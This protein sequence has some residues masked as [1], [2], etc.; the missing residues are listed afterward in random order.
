MYMHIHCIFDQFMLKQVSKK[1]FC[2][3]L[4]I[5]DGQFELSMI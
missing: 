3:C 4:A 2:I 1:E 5:R